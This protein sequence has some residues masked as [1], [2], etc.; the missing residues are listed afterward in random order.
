[1]TIDDDYRKSKENLKQRFFFPLNQETNFKMNKL[2]RIISKNKK[3]TN[4]ILNI[5]GR[6]FQIKE[7]Y[8]GV[9]RFTFEELC[10]KNLGAEDYL[11]IIKVSDFIVFCF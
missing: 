9:I 1:M 7:F 4:K 2:F 3:K 11:E 8:E 5:K 6:E 10:N